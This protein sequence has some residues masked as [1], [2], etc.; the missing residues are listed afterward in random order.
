MAITFSLKLESKHCSIYRI[1]NPA[2]LWSLTLQNIVF[3]A[4]W[5][6]FYLIIQKPT[7]LFRL[8]SLQTEFINETFQMTVAVKTVFKTSASLFSIT[9]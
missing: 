7:I 8:H 5:T 6:W 4:Y 2:L 9:C 1:I 3:H